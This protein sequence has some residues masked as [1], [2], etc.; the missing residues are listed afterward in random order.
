MKIK[1]RKKK[2]KTDKED[3]NNNNNNNKEFYCDLKWK[4]LIK[5]KIYYNF[6]ILIK[7]N[8]QEFMEYLEDNGLVYLFN[9]IN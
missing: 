1:K 4:G 2:K 7:Q 9:N 6:Q 5:K 8:L 3:D